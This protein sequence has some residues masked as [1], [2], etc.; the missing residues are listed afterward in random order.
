[1]YNFI[2]FFSPWIVPS[3]KNIEAKFMGGLGRVMW[4]MIEQLI[5]HSPPSHS[6]HLLYLWG[7]KVKYRGLQ[8]A[9]TT[10]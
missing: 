2:L 4:L 1:M 3:I 5:Y 9:P 6:I 7:L 8:G 10:F